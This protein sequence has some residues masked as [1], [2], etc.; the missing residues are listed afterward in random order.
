MVIVLLNP[1]LNLG[2][3][4]EMASSFINIYIYIGDG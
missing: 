4:A 1:T 3:L 2:Y